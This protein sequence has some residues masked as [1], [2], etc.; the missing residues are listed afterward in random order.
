MQNTA[1]PHW[2]DSNTSG[3]LPFQTDFILLSCL[4]FKNTSKILFSI[5]QNSSNPKASFIGPS[6]FHKTVNIIIYS[7]APYCMQW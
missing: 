7:L 4:Q 2:T 5:L 3:E 6:L 1:L